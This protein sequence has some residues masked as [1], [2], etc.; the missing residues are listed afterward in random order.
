MNEPDVALLLHESMALVL[1]LAGP[2]LL[3]ML[4][5]GVLVALL[6]AITQINETAL[7]FVPKLLVLGGVL[8]LMGQWMFAALATFTLHVF[9]R[10]A[11][12]GL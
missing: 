12:L 5:A 8:L 7:V 11:S 3:A 4:V 10:V 1:R 6:Q 9:A 2:P